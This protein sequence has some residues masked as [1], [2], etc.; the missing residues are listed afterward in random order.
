MIRFTQGNL[1][2]A[3]AEALVNT[4]NTV[5]VM[6]KGIAL[7]FKE[8]FPLN[9]QLYAK[10]CKD[11]QV[12]TGRMFV[13]NTESL[14][15]PKWIVNFPTKQHWKADSRLEWIE[16]GLQDLRSFLIEQKVKSIAIPPLGA[17]NGGLDW[18]VVKQRIIS[19]LSD[20][21]D[22]EI[23]IYEPTKQ[24]QNVA[25]KDGVKALTPERAMIAELIRRYWVLG[26]ECS[27][28]EVQKLAWF[29]DRVV[30]V[31]QLPNQLKFRFEPHKFGPYSQNLKHLLNGLDGTY[32]LA[33]K[34]IPDATPDDVVYFNDEQKQQVELYLRTQA[35]EYL[36]ALDQA[37]R[38][39]EGFESPYGMELLATVDWLLLEGGCEPTIESVKAGLARWPAGKHWAYRKL[40]LFGDNSLEFAIQKLN[41]FSY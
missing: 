12:Q 21:D 22:V 16:E 40:N 25:K 10:A 13:T 2:D 11:N 18:D 23:L 34:R 31:Y 9:M 1:L 27:L 15:G 29:L 20:L 37:T 30:N 38:I 33:D 17:G 19:A 14:I 4:V 41:G 5:G 7:M 3:S 24:Y 28:L 32:L 6:G 26:I 36:P 8:R 39:I 35:K